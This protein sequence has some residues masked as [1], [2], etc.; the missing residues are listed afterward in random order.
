MLR[1][2]WILETNAK[3]TK[4]SAVPL[5]L[6][7]GHVHLQSCTHTAGI[8]YTGTQQAHANSHPAAAASVGVYS[9]RVSLLDSFF[10]TSV[11]VFMLVELYGWS[12]DFKQPG[13][14]HRFLVLKSCLKRK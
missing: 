8:A 13:L 14:E 6:F 3:R 5:R 11:C 2:G 4:R 12:V 1:F 7:D 9:S 10:Q